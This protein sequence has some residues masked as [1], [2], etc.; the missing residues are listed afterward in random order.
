MVLKIMTFISHAYA[1]YSEISAILVVY[2]EVIY[3][4]IGK[5]GFDYG[6][7]SL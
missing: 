3:E 5:S 7:V 4:N 6:I 2:P 1:K